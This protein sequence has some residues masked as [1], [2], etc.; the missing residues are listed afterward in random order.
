[1]G[2]ATAAS[3]EAGVTAML[4]AEVTTMVGAWVIGVV[5]GN[6]SAEP[7]GVGAHVQLSQLSSSSSSPHVDSNGVGAGVACLTATGG[8]LFG[9][10]VGPSVGRLVGARVGARVGA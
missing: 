6:S 3:V 5:V 7:K 9:A 4:G 8:L 10:R 1:M 2:V